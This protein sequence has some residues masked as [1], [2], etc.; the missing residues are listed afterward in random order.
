MHLLVVVRGKDGDDDIRV[1]LKRDRRQLS[2]GCRTYWELQGKYGRLPT[3]LQ[4][5][6]QE[7]L[8]LEQSMNSRASK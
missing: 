8:A 5:D 3:S 1:C 7:E 2:A 6:Y 4:K